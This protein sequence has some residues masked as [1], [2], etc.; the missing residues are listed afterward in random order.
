MPVIYVTYT[1]LNSFERHGEY[2][3]FDDKDAASPQVNSSERQAWMRLLAN[4]RPDEL[5][6]L[7][8]QFTD[9][10]DY[11][12][13]RAPE[14]GLVM[15][16]GRMGGTGNPFNMGEMT[17]ARCC[18]RTA[19]GHVGFS[20]VAGR[21]RDHAGQAAL[22]D[23]MMQDTDRRDAVQEKI[24][25]PLEQSE[26]LRKAARNSVIAATKVDFF[27]MVRGED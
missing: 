25:N 14:N 8:D 24:L 19:E 26:I 10:P 3:V 7:F 23:A 2:S 20:W 22:C 27:T 17:V 5:S 9:K 6:G 1:M 4:A 16:R 13:L 12:H 21:N 15:V 18:V 11:Q